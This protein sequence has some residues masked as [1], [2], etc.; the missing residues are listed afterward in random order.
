MNSDAQA[1]GALRRLSGRIVAATHNAGK[2]RE[3]RELLRPH[4]VG[5]VGAAELGLIDPE[6]TG[7]TFRDNAKLK[8]EAAA[9]ASAAPALAD[10][11]GLCV[12]ALGD[13]PGVYSARW[14]SDSKDFGA[15]MARVEEEPLRN[16][17]ISHGGVSTTF[18]SCQSLAVG[19]ASAAIRL[20]SGECRLFR[21]DRARE[22]TSIEPDDFRIPFLGRI[23]QGVR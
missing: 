23:R 12:E 4:G 5:A 16:L 1:A 9:R 8:A 19:A 22:G 21:R 7:L 17:P 15:A 2:L 11:S 18:H 3:L 14:T 13:A 10:D 20:S 6:E